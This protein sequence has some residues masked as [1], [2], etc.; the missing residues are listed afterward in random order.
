MEPSMSPPELIA[1]EL[2]RE[3]GTVRAVIQRKSELSQDDKQQIAML[4]RWEYKLG[5]L[6]ALVSPEAPQAE[7]VRPGIFRSTKPSSSIFKAEARQ[8]TPPTQMG[9]HRHDASCEAELTSHGYTLCQCEARQETEKTQLIADIL[10]EYR[11]EQS[12]DG[13]EDCG[14]VMMC[15]FHSVLSLLQGQTFTDATWKRKQAGAPS[16]PAEPAQ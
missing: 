5:A 15:R 2:S 4:A 7:E 1:R 14:P 3:M 16:Q 9:Q 10:D 6:L 8:E 11:D 13:C 12:C